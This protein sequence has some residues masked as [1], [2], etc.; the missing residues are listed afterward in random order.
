MRV[1]GAGKAA[2]AEQWCADV[3]A[4]TGVPWRYLKV[5]DKEFK[6]LKP[7]S[8]DELVSALQAGGPMFV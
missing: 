2:R 7:T 6:K 1:A 3:T 5:P 4:L 8:F